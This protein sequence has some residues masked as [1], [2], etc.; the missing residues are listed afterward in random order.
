M[1][2]VLFV[3]SEVTPYAKS[4]GLADV[5]GSLPKE[6]LKI[7]YDMKIVMPLYRE[8]KQEMEYVTD[9]PIYM[10]GKKENCI[11][12]KHVQKVEDKDLTTY[13]IDNIKYFDRDGLYCHPDEAERFAF[14]DKAVIELI[15]IEKPDVV[16]LNDWQTGPIALLLR[17]KNKDIKTR[18]IYTIHNMEYN[19]RFNKENIYHLDL[20]DSYFT[21]EGIEFYGD[22]SF[23][24]AG[25]LYSDMITTVSKTY[26]NEIQTA[27]YG[28]GYEGLMSLKAKQGK[29][30]GITNAIDYDEYNPMTDK[31]LANNYSYKTF[32]IKKENKKALQKELG[33]DISD[34]PL[35]A[36]VSRIVSHKGYDI[37]VEGLNEILKKDV[38][39]VALGVGD[40]HYIN[41]LEY[42]REKYPNKVS[43]NNF[44]DHGLAKRIYAGSD[45][46]LMPSVFEPC[47]LSQ[48]ISFRYGTVPIVRSTGGL[49]DTVIGYGSDKEKGNGFTFWGNSV[50]DFV[51]VTNKALELYENKEEWANLAVKDMQI[52][53]SWKGPAKE[54]EKIYEGI[55][56]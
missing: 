23:S 1:K 34:I 11:V 15:R 7:G 41:R 38:Q 25:I 33:L 28:F 13:F 5:A 37:L 8:V 52:D 54:Y 21:P 27:E 16:H 51:T 6:L 53:F 47:G 40:K 45:I 12:R 56:T 39:F 29:L 20:N 19:G 46:F 9:Y 10:Q 36:I 2:K 24:K 31:E 32:K 48:L 17:E 26:A 22:M 43:I 42:L 3:A 50:F 4:G 14:F 44:F 18:I 55:S 35:L 49:R 30:V